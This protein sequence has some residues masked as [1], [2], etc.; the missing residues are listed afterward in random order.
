V[1]VGFRAIYGHSTAL[2]GGH[3]KVAFAQTTATRAS[4]VCVASSAEGDLRA[5]VK[6]DIRGPLGRR[7]Q[8]PKCYTLF[9]GRFATGN[10]ALS[11]SF[12]AT[13]NG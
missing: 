5:A 8:L 3:L 11:A 4:L 7:D 12:V 1:I 10:G 2:S 6:A 13:P 9:R